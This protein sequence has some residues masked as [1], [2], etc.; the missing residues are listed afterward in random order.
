MADSIPP[1]S[2]K[3]VRLI[4]YAFFLKEAEPLSVEQR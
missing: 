3:L 1:S 4:S 2:K